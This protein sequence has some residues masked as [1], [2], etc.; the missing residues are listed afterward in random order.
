MKGLPLSIAPVLN[1]YPTPGIVETP[2]TVTRHDRNCL[3]RLLDSARVK[4]L[5]GIDALREDLDRANEVE[6]GDI[7]PDVVTMN[8]TVRFVDEEAAREYELRLVYP[9]DAGKADTISI[10]APV[11]SALLGL[12]VG[13]SIAWQV[14]HGRRLKLR[15]VGVSN[16]PETWLR[17]VKSLGSAATTKSARRTS[18][19]DRRKHS[20]DT[21]GDRSNPPAGS[22]VQELLFRAERW[23]TGRSTS[24]YD[25]LDYRLMATFPASDPVA[26]Y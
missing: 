8:S 16:Q 2:I 22:S 21:G 25:A 15:V 3:Q 18:A 12:S 20:P 14:P 4:A 19:T 26:I 1:L 5:P 11:G 13:Q 7:A 23:S 6:P 17:H 10:F 9:H 24:E